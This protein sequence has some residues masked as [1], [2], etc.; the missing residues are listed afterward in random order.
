MQVEVQILDPRLHEWGFP[1]YG[2]DMAAGLDLHACLDE[3]LSLKPQESAVL[4]S[5]GIAVNIGDPNWCAMIF[6]RSGL[7]HKSGLVLGNSVGVIDPDYEGTCYI[8]AWN[9]NPLSDDAPVGNAI[10]IYP[11]DRIAQMV[12]T[13][14]VRPEF[15]VV[16]SFS[17]RSKRQG[18]GFGSTGV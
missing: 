2:S 14:V 18:A 13:R 6:P 11:G 3:P 16:S 7:G 4:I 8:S 9:R 1:A 10:T 15:K 17:R 12:F 5:A